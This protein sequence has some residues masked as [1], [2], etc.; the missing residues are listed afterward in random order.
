MKMFQF[1]SL[2]T[3]LSVMIGLIITVMTTILV[4]LSYYS[5]YNS[6]KEAYVNQLQNT[7]ASIDLQV[8]QFYDRQM[9]NTRF[10][11]KNDV[12]V[13][14]CGSGRYND[15]LEMFK[16]YA[17]EENIYANIFISSAEANPVVLAALAGTGTRW[18]KKEYEDNIKNAL[19]GEEYISDPTRSAVTGLPIILFTAP[20]K[21][22]EKVI[23][24]FGMTVNI[25]E[26]SSSIVNKIKIAKTGFPYILSSNGI[27]IAHPNKDLILNLDLNKY[28]WGKKVLSASNG[29][30]IKYTF[31]NLDKLIIPIKNSKYR[32]ITGVTVGISDIND[33]ARTLAV[34]MMIFALI[35]VLLGSAATY[36][37]ISRRL[38]PLDRCCEVMKHMSEGNL[39][40]RYEGVVN[41]DEIGEMALSLNTTIEQFEKVIS[42]IIHTSQN[43][44]QAVEQIATGNQNLS[45]RTSEQASSLEEIAATIEEASSSISQNYENSLQASTMSETSSSVAGRGGELVNEAI[46]S[47]NEVNASAKRI[48][49]ITTIINEIAF[50]TNLLALNAAVEAAR[51]GDQGKGFA[52]VAGE[53]RN[54]AQR[55]GN[56]AREIA[57]LIHD[58][59]TKVENG[60][61][62]TYK[63]GESLKDIITSVN[64]VASVVNEISAASKEQKNGIDQ[65]TIA[66]TDLDSMTQHN[67]ALVEETASASEEMANQAQELVS[68]MSRFTIRE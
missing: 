19:K 57:Q 67:A 68:L 15:A 55:A 37:L 5:S 29:E 4:F 64:N 43:L 49:D 24:I 66:V 13:R 36:I 53:V 27:A 12:V 17:R 39:A 32:I 51:A 8:S 22:G 28:D 20:V 60:T 23:G 1:R 56:S 40:V 2:K 34:R 65:I 7:S 45:Q 10:F 31:N 63:T 11:S 30:I 26:F 58:T 41:K 46:N 54:L 9:N 42:E 14:A 62:K 25:G 33:D 61:E 48:G 21:S 3:F 18:Y 50:Q 35:A 16:S 6:V 47:I 52:V 44:A 59:I 38:K